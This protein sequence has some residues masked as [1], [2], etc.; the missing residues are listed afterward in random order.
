MS[1]SWTSLVFGF[2]IF[3]SCNFFN[4]FFLSSSCRCFIFCIVSEYRCFVHRRRLLHTDTEIVNGSL[5][6]TLTFLTFITRTAAVAAGLSGEV[7]GELCTPGVLRARS[8]SLGPRGGVLWFNHA[9]SHSHSQYTSRLCMIT[10]IIASLGTSF[11]RIWIGWQGQHPAK[12][13]AAAAS[14][15]LA[16]HYGP[17]P[18]FLWRNAQLSLQS[19]QRRARSRQ[20]GRPWPCAPRLDRASSGIASGNYYYY[21]YCN[22]LSLAQTTQPTIRYFIYAG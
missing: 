1:E 22:T 6:V 7:G 15:G 4:L 16:S 10:P 8:S 18:P 11:L 14:H 5:G 9:Q 13:R 17:E 2:L 3:F 12:T 20:G 19:R 21:R